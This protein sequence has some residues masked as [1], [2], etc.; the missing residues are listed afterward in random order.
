MPFKTSIS[1]KRL[2]ML[3]RL[4]IISDIALK[5]QLHYYFYRTH[6]L[7]RLCKLLLTTAKSHH[8]QV[9]IAHKSTPLLIYKYT[10]IYCVALLVD[11]MWLITHGL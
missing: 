4:N 10:G 8:I 3:V 2:C 7:Q 6:F 9:I 1:P 11:Y 5:S